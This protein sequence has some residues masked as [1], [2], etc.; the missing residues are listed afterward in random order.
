MKRPNWPF[1][2]S[3]TK[4]LPPNLWIY[5]RRLSASDP[6]LSKLL[7]A[8]GHEKR[9]RIVLLLAERGPLSVTEL[10]REM[11]ISTGSLYHNIS[12][13]G[14]LVGQRPDRKYILTNKGA[15]ANQLLNEGI[16]ANEPR[17]DGG[18]GSRFSGLINL[19]MP[20]WIF[21]SIAESRITALI[22]AAA[23]LL[24]GTILATPA[25]A[26]VTLLL[27]ERTNSGP[28]LQA[29]SL[30]LSWLVVSFGM[31]F[32][33]S[34]GKIRSSNAQNFLLSSALSY[35][36]QVLYLVLEAVTRAFLGDFLAG[37]L[38]FG[39]ASLIFSGLGVCLLATALATNFNI[40]NERALIA[41]L[42]LFYMSSLLSNFSRNI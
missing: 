5:V 38:I 9:R 27:V 37:P 16:L 30:P 29:L 20:R 33:L 31:L 15:R 28:L 8:L 25:K 14:D 18:L 36:P 35:T 41:C 40:R 11:K 2:H 12:L 42:V 3:D 39:I 4:F 23:V 19:M 17:E 26:S 32:L 1:I 22:G 24:A 10:K 6:E 13:L 34:R 21:L 7:V